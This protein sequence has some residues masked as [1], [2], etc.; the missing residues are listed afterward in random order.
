MTTTPCDGL[1]CPDAARCPGRELIAAQI[2]AMQQACPGLLTEVEAF[3]AIVA[4][5]P[6]L[7]WRWN[8]MRAA[9]AALPVLYSGVRSPGARLLC[10]RETDQMMRAA[11]GAWRE[12]YVQVVAVALAEVAPS[13]RRED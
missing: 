12:L 7:G 3:A 10:L 11:Q 5:T 8:R 1:C 13:L 2:R 6:H 4:A 9:R